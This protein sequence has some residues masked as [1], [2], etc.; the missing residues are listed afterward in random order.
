MKKWSFI[1]IA[2][3]IG[4]TGYGQEKKLRAYMDN[5]QFFAPEVGN[6][7]EF[8]LQF[9]GYSL[10][11]TGRDGGLVGEVG[12]RTDIY[13]GDSL[14]RSDA[15]RLE[16]PLM[17]DS[18]VEDFYDV[19]RFALPPGTYQ[20]QIELVDMKSDGEPVKASQNFVVEDLS[21]AVSFS[22]IMVAEAAIRGGEGSPLY[23]SGYI[24]IPR[25]APFYP[26]ELNT[27]P[28]YFELYNTPMLEE[29][30]F[31]IKQTIVDAIS[32]EELEGFSAFQRH[33][34]GSVVPVL[35]SIDISEVPTGKYILR[36]TLLS[37][38]LIEIAVQDYDFERS[39][40]LQLALNP[41]EVILDPEF[42]ASITDDSVMYYLESLIPI[43]RP[44]EVRNI[45]Q[46]A[47]NGV[48]ENARK[49]I[50]LFWK[51]TSP[52][53]TYEAWI[54]YKA[55]VQLTERVY[56]NN[57]QEGFET[58]RG[59]VYLQYG[60]PTNIIRREV[61]ANEYPFEIWMYNKIGRFSN[62][63]FV[64]YNPDLTNNAYRLLH[65]DM[66]GELKNPS[67]QQEMQKRN[68]VNGNIENPNANVI[69]GFGGDAIEYFDQY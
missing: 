59:R 8:H 20:F 3:L 30:E 46:I 9:V 34:P 58:D 31:G 12:V 68:S 62:K 56:A 51:V 23:K 1:L 26:Q 53:K 69:D 24:L 4:A 61:S 42:Q 48:A 37:R 25:L 54:N 38:N 5:K 13:K 29:E 60:S 64:F 66:V 39:N 52:E 49:H 63:R 18:I 17:R 19:Q 32:G 2:V 45:I 55:Q 41:N 57:F 15:Y 44:N 36:Y 50:Q 7:V 6:Y 27:I 10:N 11:Y 47:K 22:D 21:D 40:E 14:V 43:S 35:R 33:K 67:W 28:V 65:S 16:S